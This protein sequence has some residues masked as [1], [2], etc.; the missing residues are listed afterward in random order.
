MVFRTLTKINCISFIVIIIILIEAMDL[1]N[2]TREGFL[3]KGVSRFLDAWQCM[4]VYPIFKRLMLIVRWNTFSRVDFSDKVVYLFLLVQTSLNRC[5]Q[6]TH[7][8]YLQLFRFNEL[9]ISL[10]QA[11]RSHYERFQFPL[12]PLHHAHRSFR[13]L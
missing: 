7:L 13:M 1:L 2:R 11:L 12:K 10:V 5:I 9:V 4:E 3:G 6:F 8:N